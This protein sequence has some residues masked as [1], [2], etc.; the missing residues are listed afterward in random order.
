MQPIL[1][2][3]S[4]WEVSQFGDVRIVLVDE[5]GST[6]WKYERFDFSNPDYDGYGGHF[7]GAS[8]VVNGK[9]A[10]SF[11]IVGDINFYI[12]SGGGDTKGYILLLD[13]NGG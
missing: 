12:N 2:K 13:Q 11:V 9:Y 10:D 6:V 8:Y 5:G 7:S 3:C 1:K 4:L